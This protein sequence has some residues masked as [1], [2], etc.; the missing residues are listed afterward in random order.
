M[1]ITYTVTLQQ[2]EFE[3]D[4]LSHSH[5]TETGT[6]YKSVQPTF[7]QEKEN[8]P[9]D[10][11][12][13]WDNSQHYNIENGNIHLNNITRI[14]GDKRVIP[15][16]NGVN[17]EASNE[18]RVDSSEYVDIF[19]TGP[20]LGIR[21][22]GTGSAMTAMTFKRDK[23]SM[24][25]EKE[26]KFIGSAAAVLGITRDQ[27]TEIYNDGSYITVFEQK[28]P[29]PYCNIKGSNIDVVML[30]YLRGAIDYAHI[31][32]K[33]SLTEENFL[34]SC[35]YIPLKDTGVT[36]WDF[37]DFGLDLSVK[38]FP[39]YSHTIVVV[40]IK[41]RDT[42][43]ITNR[44]IVSMG[45]DLVDT[46]SGT[47]SV[48]GS[49]L[50][51]LDRKTVEGFYVFYGVVPSVYIKTEKPVL[52]IRLLMDDSTPLSYASITSQDNHGSFSIK[53]PLVHISMA[54]APEPSSTQIRVPLRYSEFFLEPESALRINDKLVHARDAFWVKNQ[55]D[56]AIEI[57]AP[58]GL[59]DLLEPVR[60]DPATNTLISTRRPTD[61]MHSISDI[62]AVYGLFRH[63]KVSRLSL[64]AATSSKI[65]DIASVL[66]SSSG[67]GEGHF[68]IGAWSQGGFK[69]GTL[70]SV[71]AQGTT[72]NYVSSGPQV[73]PIR[74]RVVINVKPVDWG[75]EIIL[76]GWAIEASIVIKEVGAKNFKSF[77][78]WKFIAPDIIILDKEFA[79]P[80]TI[81]TIA[82]DVSVHPIIRTIDLEQGVF[83]LSRDVPVIEAYPGYEGLFLLHSK[84][85]KI[86]IGYSDANGS[87]IYLDREITAN[88]G[89]NQNYLDRVVTGIKSTII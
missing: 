67:Y 51:T 7:R 75:Y 49:F 12:D 63:G 14:E 33:F 48:S 47:I 87:R 16:L 61:A 23:G 82:Y 6:P 66:G 80:K 3:S 1:E 38:Y 44:Q 5:A 72:V 76:P 56:N 10:L 77:N 64:A 22:S 41:D 45:L 40:R 68:G 37:A 27:Y 34:R 71:G 60:E 2:E 52:P 89:L 4:L 83:T 11:T 53:E 15:T 30:D 58:I 84:Q 32:N 59:K 73:L 70:A 43:T 65:E 26:Y 31:I 21:S 25:I 50:S 8:N 36:E 19:G 42:G 79:D 78:N 55:G 85:V 57:R 28:D 46:K 9:L 29:T 69:F 74:S 62:A 81:Y 35:E 54:A 39:I 13:G 20:R 17:I 24:S 18:V 86:R 88:M